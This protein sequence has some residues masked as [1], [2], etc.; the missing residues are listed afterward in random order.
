MIQPNSEK[1]VKE[2]LNYSIKSPNNIYLRFCSI[3]FE[4]PDKFDELSKLK[5]V[6]EIQFLMVK[7]YYY[8]AQYY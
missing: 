7:N 3:P 8:D 4:L 6:M 5:K 1:Q 2:F